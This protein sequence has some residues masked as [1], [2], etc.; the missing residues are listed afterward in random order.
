MAGESYDQAR[1]E[2]GA[3]L[4]KDGSE[5]V[6]AAVVA[7]L[8]KI[9]KLLTPEQRERFAYLIRTGAISI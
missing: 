5:R 6:R 2:E 1:A 4:R 3:A 7:A 9:H 8:P